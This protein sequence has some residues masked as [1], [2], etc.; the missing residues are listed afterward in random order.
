MKSQLLSIAFCLSA[1]SF[2]FG[3]QYYVGA[4]VGSTF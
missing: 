2:S 4:A 3:Q 1:V